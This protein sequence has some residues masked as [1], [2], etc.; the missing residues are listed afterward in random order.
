MSRWEFQDTLRSMADTRLYEMSLDIIKRLEIDK[1]NPAMKH[2][3]KIY[4]IQRVL[5]RNKATIYYDAHN[6]VMLM[7]GKPKAIIRNSSKH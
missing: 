5:R 1:G 6:Q 3:G 7:I 2:N 4:C